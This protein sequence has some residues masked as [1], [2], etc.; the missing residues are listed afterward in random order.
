MNAQLFISPKEG[1]EKNHTFEVRTWNQTTRCTICDKILWGL[2]DQGYHCQV[3]QESCHR[4]CISRAN[5]CTRGCRAHTHDG[6]LSTSQGHSKPTVMKRNPAKNSY[7]EGGTCKPTY[8]AWCDYN[9]DPHPGGSAPILL[10]KKG[11]DIS[12]VSAN[13][14]DWWEGKNNRTG[15]MGLFPS[16]AVKIKSN[17]GG[18]YMDVMIGQF[19]PPNRDQDSYN[20]SMDDPLV[21]FRK[22]VADS[23]TE[24]PWY[25][26]KMSRHEAEQILDKCENG[27]FLM[28]ES[29]QRPGEYALAI[30]YEDAPK[31]IKIS[32]NPRSKVFFMVEAQPFKSLIPLVEYYSVNSLNV[33]FQGI[34]TKLLTP[35]W[36]Y[37]PSPQQQIPPTP[38]MPQFTM[39]QPLPPFPVQSRPTHKL[40]SNA[41][42]RPPPPPRHHVRMRQSIAYCQALY[43]YEPTGPSELAL[44]T[45]QNIKLMNKETEHAG[46]W[47]G[48][49]EGRIGLFP[50]NYVRL[51]EFIV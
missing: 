30:R 31:H 44:V 10:F 15:Q 45:G 2:F 22:G 6:S 34:N 32:Y 28:R 40:S 36:S 23:L 29:D 41:P 20:E 21:S 13:D 11:D 26:G 12:I 35:Y 7:G 5:F 19:Q 50:A 48:E 43:N 3:C 16:R 8:T 49:V 24:Q 18:S 46:W 38:Y 33:C 14:R 47:L 4:S 42:P 1:S 37:A 9:A 39:Q 27:V 25:L 51:N 17:A